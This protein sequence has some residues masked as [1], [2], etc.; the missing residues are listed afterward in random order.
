[1]R[2]KLDVFLAELEGIIENILSKNNLKKIGTEVV[3]D[4]KVRT[5]LGEG[6]KSSGSRPS[7]FAS[8]KP[9]TIEDRKK[10]RRLSNLTR[11][12]LSNLTRTG[13]MVNSISFKVKTN[14]IQIYLKGNRNNK[15]ATYHMEGTK[16]MPARPFFNLSNFEVDRVQQMLQVALDEY[17]AEKFNNEI[18]LI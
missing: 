11:P 6:V 3:H 5:T 16:N 4:M 1:M 14:S 10:V 9:A 12:N 8:L 15:I 7:S 2:Q 18:S 17:L 13:K